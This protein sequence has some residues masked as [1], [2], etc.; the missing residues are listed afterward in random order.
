MIQKPTHWLTSSSLLNLSL[1]GASIS[2]CTWALSNSSRWGVIT[3]SKHTH[4]YP[5][6]QWKSSCTENSIFKNTIFCSSKEQNKSVSLEISSHSSSVYL[7]SKLFQLSRFVQQ[8]SSE[9]SQ[10]QLQFLLLS[11]SVAQQALQFTL[12]PGE[13]ILQAAKK[14]GHLGWV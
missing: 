7:Q 14:K 4:L 12:S 1:T 8:L 6:G 9:L 2:C 13:L 11:L 5:E 3:W 10:Q